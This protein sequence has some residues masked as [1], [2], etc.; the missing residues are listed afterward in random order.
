M[1][2]YQRLPGTLLLAGYALLIAT[3]VYGMAHEPAP[4]IK[5]V[6]GGSVVTL[7]WNL[8]L[9]LAGIVGLLARLRGAKH[10][11]IIAVDITAAVML[12][13]SVSVWL[14]S[15]SNQGALAFGALSMLLFGWASA[16]RVRLARRTRM[17]DTVTKEG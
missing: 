4:A 12:I 3:G 10:T 17:E 1:T 2:L 9:M 16:T 11:E 8:A 7:A 6:V 13:W 15:T 5:E 14:A